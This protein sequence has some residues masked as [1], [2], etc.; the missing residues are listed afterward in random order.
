MKHRLLP[1]LMAATAVYHG[2]AQESISVSF[3]E[4]AVQDI[5]AF[6]GRLTGFHIVADSQVMG[7]LSLVTTEPVSAAKAIELVEAVL[8]ANGFS[9][10]Q[11]QPDTLQIVGLGRS[12]RSEALPIVTTPEQLPKGERVVS[13]VFKLKHRNPDEI[14]QLLNL[15]YAPSNSMLPSIIPDPVSR[16][17]VV[18]ARSSVLREMIRLVSELDVAKSQ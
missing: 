10:I 16:C 13:Y 17:L 15:Q 12:A 2:H 9:I 7:Q 4:A 6:Y 8:F 3:P 18:T 5:L 11:I 1:I 14:A